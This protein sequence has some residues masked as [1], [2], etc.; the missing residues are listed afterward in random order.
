MLWLEDECLLVIEP[1]CV[2]TW[3]TWYTSAWG[4]G[5]SYN[6]GKLDWKPPWPRWLQPWPRWLTKARSSE[7]RGVVLTS[8]AMRDPP[9]D[10]ETEPRETF[11]NLGGI[12]SGDLGR[13]SW[14]AMSP[15]GVALFG[16]WWRMGPF[17]DNSEKI[18]AL[19][20]WELE[21]LICSCSS[22]P[23]TWAVRLFL[24]LSSFLVAAVTRSFAS[25]TI[26]AWLI[27]YSSKCCQ[28]NMHCRIQSNIP[29]SP[30]LP[31]TPRS[32]TPCEMISAFFAIGHACFST[33]NKVLRLINWSWFGLCSSYNKSTLLTSLST[34]FF[35][36]AISRAL[37]L[38]GHVS[39][40]L[41]FASANEGAGGPHWA[42]LRFAESVARAIS[43]KFVFV[44]KCCAATK[45]WAKSGSQFEQRH[46]GKLLS[47]CLASSVM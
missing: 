3:W 33:L 26:S 4:R 19:G 14:H 11:G 32:E 35:T 15:T 20:F 13:P 28:S 16:K 27:T 29:C 22:R 24:V 44:A 23:A 39:K 43:L 30:S 31:R 38:G 40:F 21:V 36:I 41:R 7:K 17:W 2:S 10:C 1:G 34:K 6:E 18:C 47:P 8:K 42:W 9:F 37:S 46:V 45:V 5:R 25:L 12:K